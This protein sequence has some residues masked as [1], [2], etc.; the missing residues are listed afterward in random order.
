MFMELEID[1]SQLTEELEAIAAAADETPV[2]ASIITDNPKCL[3]YWPV[4]EYGSKRGQRPWPRPWKRT[5]I[6]DGSRI[7]SKQAVDGWIMK[8]ALQLRKSVV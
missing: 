8:Y 7:F 3:D 6:G 5:A 4:L 1:D 2:E